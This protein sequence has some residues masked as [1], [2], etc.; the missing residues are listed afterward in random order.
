MVGIQL[1]A[2]RTG[3]HCGLGL[4]LRLELSE[5][6]EGLKKWR[7]G[8]GKLGRK[9]SSRTMQRD[10]RDEPSCCASLTPAQ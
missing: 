10:R 6:T 3:G 1:G 2:R 8:R 4:G 5:E 9:G 7:S